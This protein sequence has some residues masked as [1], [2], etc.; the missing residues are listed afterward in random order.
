MPPA[1]ARASLLEAPI[2]CA[3][4][5]SATAHPLQ[6]TVARSSGPSAV[7]TGNMVRFGN[8]RAFRGGGQGVNRLVKGFAAA[9]AIA[10]CLSLTATAS[11]AADNASNQTLY[12]W[13][14]DQTIE[15]IAGTKDSRG[16]FVADS[17][18]P[19]IT[20]LGYQRL[21]PTGK[22]TACAISSDGTFYKILQKGLTSEGK[23]TITA[24]SGPCSDLERKVLIS[25]HSA[26]G[27]E[28]TSD[29]LAGL[30][31]GI[32]TNVL[33][34]DDE[35]RAWS[36]RLSISQNIYAAPTMVQS[37]DRIEYTSIVGNRPT[38]DLV[39]SDE[40]AVFLLGQPRTQ[41]NTVAYAT[42]SSGDPA[43]AW[44]QTLPYVVAVLA[45]AGAAGT[46]MASR[47]Q[48]V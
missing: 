22:A 3:L 31:E 20:K 40:F 14:N 7:R 34:L 47:R 21:S 1:V 41:R 30:K 45:V 48:H 36:G 18:Q 28:Y 42:P 17:T 37:S 13:N 27:S 39:D 35:G 4:G 9:G 2:C 44:T 12:F 32:T 23:Q 38:G 15:T 6:R 25:G 46:V 29:Y 43:A 16:N 8:K 11:A 10:A 5:I 26:R 24:F 33:S 19:T